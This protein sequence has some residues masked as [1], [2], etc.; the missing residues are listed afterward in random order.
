MRNNHFVEY[1]VEL[2]LFCQNKISIKIQH[3][4]K[5]TFHLLI[6]RHGYGKPIVA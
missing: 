1:A 4:A 3:E 2:L 6:L 5:I